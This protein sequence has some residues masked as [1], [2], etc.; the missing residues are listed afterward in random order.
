M[1]ID[2]AALEL[3]KSLGVLLRVHTHLKPQPTPQKETLRQFQCFFSHRKHLLYHR[4]L[5]SSLL[6]SRGSLINCLFGLYSA[7]LFRQIILKKRKRD[8]CKMTLVVKLVFIYCYFLISS[9][10]FQHLFLHIRKKKVYWFFFVCIEASVWKILIHLLRPLRSHA[11][12]PAPLV[13]FITSPS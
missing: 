11:L 12:S 7:K 10:F 3:M 1:R 9:V 13:T 8:I 2:P 5:S 4:K 6:N